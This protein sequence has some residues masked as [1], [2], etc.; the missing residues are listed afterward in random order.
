MDSSP[1]GI[2]QT[3]ISGGPALIFG[4]MWFLERQ[5]RLKISEKLINTLGNVSEMND[6]WLKILKNQGK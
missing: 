4:V 5:E 6:A 1:V 3:I 2:I